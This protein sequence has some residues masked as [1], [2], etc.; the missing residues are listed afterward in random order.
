MSMLHPVP[1]REWGSLAALFGIDRLAELTGTSPASVRRYMS[2]ARSTPDP[3]AARL[4]L[5]AVIS[6]DLAGAYNEI[7]IRRWFE[8]PRTFLDGKAP[9]EL[10]QGEWD[11]E[12]DGPKRVRELARSLTGSPAT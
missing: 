8:R 2:G 5:L 1:S 9:A 4:H 7:G 3:L 10:L 12:D 6:G 11:P